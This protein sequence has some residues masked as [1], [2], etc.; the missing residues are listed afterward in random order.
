MKK[1]K[2]GDKNE[3]LQIQQ[4]KMLLYSVIQIIV[5]FKKI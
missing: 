2:R 5:E 3:P 1:Y 4:K